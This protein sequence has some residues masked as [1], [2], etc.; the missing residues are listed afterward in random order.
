MM[1]ISA[2]GISRP[3]PPMPGWAGAAWAN[4]GATKKSSRFM[5]L[6][7]RYRKQPGIM[8]RAGRARPASPVGP[9]PKRPRRRR[10]VPGRRPQAAPPKGSALSCK[11]GLACAPRRLL[12]RR[13]QQ[14]PPPNRTS[15]YRSAPWARCSTH[16][17]RKASRA[18]PAPTGGKEMR[19]TTGAGGPRPAPRR[20]R[21]GNPG[22]SPPRS[23]PASAPSPAGST[24]GCAGCRASEPASRCSGPGDA[25]NCG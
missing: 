15:L 16:D 12:M 4:T 8:P 3:K 9:D 22:T 19:P 2:I 17:P 21:P 5:D 7:S 6:S 13:G 23:P 10:M 1:A 20:R 14:R 25:G 24:R 18:W 11:A